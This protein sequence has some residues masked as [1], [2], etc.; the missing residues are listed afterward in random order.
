[1]ISIYLFLLLFVNVGLCVTLPVCR[2]S[3]LGCWC[4]P[5]GS[6]EAYCA[7]STSA[8]SVLLLYYSYF[9]KLFQMTK[10]FEYVVKFVDSFFS[11]GFNQM[12]QMLVVH[13]VIRRLLF[14]V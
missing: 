7:P 5:E 2:M 11:L 1:M 3:Q 14:V 9:K 4:D 8:M 12:R 6:T 10:W 13:F